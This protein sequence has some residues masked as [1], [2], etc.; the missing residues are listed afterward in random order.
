MKQV[1][2]IVISTKMPRGIATTRKL[3]AKGK[4]TN[5]IRAAAAPKNE[6]K[7]IQ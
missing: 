6:D 4:I 2:D 1:E 5:E 3:L 7:S